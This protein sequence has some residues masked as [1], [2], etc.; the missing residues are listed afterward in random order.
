MLSLK[1]F[2]E[3]LPELPVI[4]T[5][6]YMGLARHQSVSFPVGKVRL[7]TLRPLSFL[8]F[9]ENSSLKPVA[10]MIATGRLD[11]V[12]RAFEPML[13][14]QLRTYMIVGGMSAPVA[15]YKAG[16]PLTEVRRLQNEILETYDADF[17]K[18]SSPRILERIRLIWHSLLSQLAKENRR[19]VYGAVRKGARARDFEESI[20]WLRDYGIITQVPCVSALRQPL[21]SYAKLNIFKMFTVNIGLMAALAGL[22]PSTL[23]SGKILPTSDTEAAPSH[24]PSSPVFT[25]AAFT[26]FKGALTEQYVCQQLAAQDLRLYYWANPRGS[27]EIDFDIERNG[28]IVPIEVKAEKNLYSKSLQYACKHFGLTQ[29]VKTSMAGYK[30]QDGLTNIPLWAIGGLAAW[31]DRQSISGRL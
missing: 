12:D 11:E 10:E 29:A 30:P 6:S 19:F 9:L 7:M 26:E 3:D 4:A 31:L 1:Y 20:Q 25:S 28:V 21:A 22:S 27:A 14:E 24:D 18:R 15:A 13:E 2:S 16:Q 8:E 5:G 17:T 23:I